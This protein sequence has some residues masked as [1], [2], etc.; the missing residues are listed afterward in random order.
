MTT[1]VCNADFDCVAGDTCVAVV[2]TCQ[3]LVGL[4]GVCASAFGDRP[5]ADGF[6]CNATTCAALPKVGDNCANTQAC[7]GGYCDLSGN[8]PAC[9]AYLNTG[10]SCSDA[11]H[12]ASQLLTPS[13]NSTCGAPGD[14][15]CVTP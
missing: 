12:C 5:C 3:P 1:A 13:P 10:D 4:G 9:T 6:W 14:F 11:S 2:S 15:Y 8:A 7:T